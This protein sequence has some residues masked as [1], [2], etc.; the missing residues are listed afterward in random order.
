MIQN[1]EG[2]SFSGEL[3]VQLSVS[4]SGC[5]IEYLASNTSLLHTPA[6]VDSSTTPTTPAE[7]EDAEQRHRCGEHEATTLTS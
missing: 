6:Y 7:R 5:D 1:A 2:D 4:Q 3:H